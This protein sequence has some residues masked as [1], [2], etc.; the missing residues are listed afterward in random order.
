MAILG[1][2]SGVDDPD[3]STCEV[4][5]VD[6]GVATGATLIAALRSVRSAAPG[7]L[8]CAVPVGPPETLRRLER[9]ADAVVCPN[10]PVMFAAVGQWYEDFSQTTDQEVIELLEADQPKT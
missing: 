1:P 3:Y 6:D 10:R 7:R 2:S 4:A 9:E 5:V 8:I